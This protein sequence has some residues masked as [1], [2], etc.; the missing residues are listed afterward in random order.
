MW[1]FP[2]TLIKEQNVYIHP[3][4]LY[5]GLSVVVKN[6]GGTPSSVGNWLLEFPKISHTIKVAPIGIYDN[7]ARQLTRGLGEPPLK[8]ADSLLKQ[9]WNGN[10]IAPLIP[11]GYIL[12]EGDSS[13]KNLLQD[14]EPS[15]E[16]F[17][18]ILHFSDFQ[19]TTALPD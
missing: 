9:T 3:E 11:A 19:N 7:P 1:H 2:G 12:F 8:E 14:A 18:C 16:A 13:V 4:K 15:H 5:V 17:D 6:D 10:S